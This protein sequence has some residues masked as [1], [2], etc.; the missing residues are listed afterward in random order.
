MAAVAFDTYKMVKRLKES[1]FTDPQ[2]EAVTAAVQEAG[3]I[4]L[5]HL[6]TNEDLAAAKNELK[7]DIAATKSD[8]AAAKNELKSD[9]AATKADIA[10]VR[11]EMREMELRITIKLGAMMAAS[12]AIVAGLVKLIH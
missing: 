7:S 11:G 4:D 5:S 6:A 2:A 3:S 1:G 12:I 10:T 9:I 8:L